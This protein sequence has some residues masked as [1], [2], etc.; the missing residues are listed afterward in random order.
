MEQR[1]A[2]GASHPPAKYAQGPARGAYLT[3]NPRPVNSASGNRAG[4]VFLGGG[5][6]RPDA[7]CQIPDTGC[8]I[9]DTGYRMPDAG[10]RMPDAGSGGSGGYRRPAR[11]EKRQQAA[12]RQ[13]RVRGGGAKCGAERME[14]AGLP[15][16]WGAAMGAGNTG[17]AQTSSLLYRGF[18][19][20]RGRASRAAG[21]TGSRRYSR[22]ETCA[23]GRR[24]GAVGGTRG[25]VRSPNRIGGR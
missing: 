1:R 21:P 9:P 10:C 25:R 4:G 6:R 2:D 3:M 24:R 8:Q 12:A 20:R 19:T 23:T 7:G 11:W 18:P 22:W 17:V 5:G 14:C 16:L 13:T 15:A